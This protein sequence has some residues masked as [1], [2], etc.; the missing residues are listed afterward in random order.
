MISA[1]L[2]VSFTSSSEPQPARRPEP[3]PPRWPHTTPKEFVS[4]QAPEP[5]G[6]NGAAAPGTCGR[7]RRPSDSER[8]TQDSS[9][10][11]RP[12]PP[13]ASPLEQAAATVS[14]AAGQGAGR[15]A[16]QPAA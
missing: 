11:T 2:I 10:T 15:T 13:A 14:A 1:S 4:A 12:P 8:C 7:P 3:R 6:R 9:G 16:P 5:G